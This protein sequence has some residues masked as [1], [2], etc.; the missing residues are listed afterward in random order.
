MLLAQLLGIGH[1]GLVI[2]RQAGKVGRPDRLFLGADEGRIA[3]GAVDR[4]CD[5]LDE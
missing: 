1:E 4:L 2:C 5:L 3:T